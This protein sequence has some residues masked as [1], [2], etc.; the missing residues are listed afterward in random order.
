MHDPPHLS[1]LSAPDTAESIEPV[2]Q[3]R[4]TRFLGFRLTRIE[5][6]LHRQFVDCVK[7]LDLKP[8]DFSLLVLVDANAGINQR[9]LSEVL[10]VSPP[11]LAIVVA[12]LVKRRLLRQVRGTQDRRM[13]HL[14]LTASGK[15]LLGKAEIDVMRLED[16]FAL[17][18]SASEAKVL[19]RV[20]DK[21]DRA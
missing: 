21:L 4:L 12:R 13:Q 18:L 20:L 3:A 6:R 19:Q 15:T 9:Q 1:T 17:G 11:N 2:D 16:Q 7:A 5:L 10:D 14:Y 8:V